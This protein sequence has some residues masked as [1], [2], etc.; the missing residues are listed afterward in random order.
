MV[1]K[2]NTEIIEATIGRPDCIV[3]FSPTCPFLKT[4]TVEH[5]IQRVVSGQNTSAVSMFKVG[6]L[7]PL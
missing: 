3:Q 1:T 7:S 4:S 5:G 6:V 2:H